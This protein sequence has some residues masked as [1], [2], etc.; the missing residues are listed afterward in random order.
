VE[1]RA[2]ED[3]LARVDGSLGRL[4]CA[5]PA[6]IRNEFLEVSLPKGSPQAQSAG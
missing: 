1:M 4:A 6:D 3:L 2:R 5:V